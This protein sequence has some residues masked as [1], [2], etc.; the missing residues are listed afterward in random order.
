MTSSTAEKP[1][2]NNEGKKTLQLSVA[3]VSSSKA[4]DG[5]EKE[6]SLDC[7]SAG[8]MVP[9]PLSSKGAFKTEFPSNEKTQRLA[10]AQLRLAGPV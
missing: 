5:S 9:D 7:F 8:W 6:D 10:A 4:F 3:M 2:E 1:H